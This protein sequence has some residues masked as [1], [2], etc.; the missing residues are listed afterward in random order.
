M[1]RHVH[2]LFIFLYV[3][4]LNATIVPGR[5]ECIEYA[6]LGY[7]YSWINA[8]INFDNVLNAY[9]ALFQVVSMPTEVSDLVKNILA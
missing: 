4:Q 1:T 9:L 2:F 7:N 5:N 3:F 8:P 6:K